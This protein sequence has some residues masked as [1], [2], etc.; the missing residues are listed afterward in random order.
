[1]SKGPGEVES[2]IA[3]L[4]AASRD[5]RAL[6]VADIANHAFRLEGRTATRA[7]RLSA[8][9]AAHRILRRLRDVREQSWKATAE[10]HQQ[11]EAAVGP[12][13]TYPKPPKPWNTAAWKAA[14]EAYT[15]AEAR[16]EAAFKATQAHRRVEKLNA[17]VGRLAY[18]WRATAI[19][20]GTLYFHE[21]YFPVRLW[22]VL[23]QR[24]GVVWADAEV[25]K[26]GERFVTVRYAG[27]TGRLDRLR[28]LSSWAFWR[29]CMFV[30]SR[31]G[32]AARILDE[33]WQDR[34]GNAAG[35]V[36]PAM[37]MPLAAAMKLLRVS[38]NF[39][40]DDVLAAF[41]RE[42]KKAHPDLGGTA[43]MFQ[44]LV[45]ARD[46]LLASIGTSAPAPKPPS[47]APQG[48]RVVYRSGRRPGGARL[49]STRRIAGG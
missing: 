45:E 2:R 42:V 11:A 23:V 15:T 48:V 7:Q 21:A 9:R 24:A 39:T 4:F 18:D 33:M 10:A 38:D 31:D 17:F 40:R 3:E 16:Y 25:V 12:H 46:R 26:V 5:S 22:A 13:P 27:V 44:R 35:G 28:L 6:S 14:L 47:Y 1:M 19:K 32:R 37:Q 8:T 36:P 20:D 34:Y 43:E 41:R 29:G 49:G 30:S